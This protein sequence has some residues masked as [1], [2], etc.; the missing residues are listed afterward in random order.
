MRSLITTYSAILTYV[1]N[2]SCD[3]GIILNRARDKNAQLEKLY[4][5][6][7]SDLESISRQII[8]G[9]R[10]YDEI[11]VKV[12][13]Y[14]SLMDDA[15]V[16]ISRCDDEID[17]IYS[18]PI[19]RTYTDSD[20]D[21]YTVEEI[22]EAALSAARRA[23]YRAQAEYEIYRD[24]YDNTNSVKYEISSMLNRFE[25]IKSGIEIIAQMIQ[26]DI[27]EIKKYI[28]SIENE[29]NYN[30]QHT[31]D[32]AESVNVYLNSKAIF[33]PVGARYFEFA[34]TNGGQTITD[35]NI[36]DGITVE[37]CI[38]TTTNSGLPNW[39][40]CITSKI[41]TKTQM[42]IF[43]NASLTE[44]FVN[45]R[46]CLMK[47]IDMDY[48]DTKTGM[49]NR[50]R[51]AKGLSP[52]DADS[53]EKIELHHIG[54]EFDSPFAEL[55][56]DSEHGNGNHSVLHNKSAQSWRNDHSMVLAYGQQKKAYWKTRSLF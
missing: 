1:D 46:A 32:T 51:M 22:D 9:R 2:L 42:H 33:M 18:H 30:L 20:G 38:N 39:S 53:H 17:Y 48:I 40:E 54:Q 19:A 16:E 10:I 45:G 21:S 12:E 3:Y 23:R 11:Q 35:V 36:C 43:L 13:K 26:S 55:T 8:R 34:A 41:E 6:V 7:Q 56:A 31:G 28:S 25:S 24:K 52:F 49:T 37:K 14:K 5:E 29:A 4:Y 50:E 47:K 15:A 44:G 27:Y